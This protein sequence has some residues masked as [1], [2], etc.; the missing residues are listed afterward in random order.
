MAL[1]Q[2][3]HFEGSSNAALVYAVQCDGGMG[4][5]AVRSPVELWDASSLLDSTV[6]DRAESE[7]VLGLPITFVKI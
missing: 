2:I 1:N 6:L 3:L 4:I 5:M 7:I